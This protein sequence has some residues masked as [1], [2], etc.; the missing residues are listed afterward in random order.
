MFMGRLV[1]HPND[2]LIFGRATALAYAPGRDDASRDE[3]AL[4]RWKVNWPHHIRVHDGQF[5]AGSLDNGISLYELMDELG[6]GAL[7]S[8]QRNSRAGHG[9]TNPRLAY[10]RQPDVRLSDEGQRWMNQHLD[11]AIAVHGLQGAVD[12]A[13]LDWLPVPVT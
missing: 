6:A 2:I 5:L 7:A 11:D 9:N 4:R 12:L 13:T 10:P 1:S 8:T 3:I